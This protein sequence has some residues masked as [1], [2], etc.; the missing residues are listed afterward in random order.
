[1]SS[2]ARQTWLSV[3][4]LL[5]GVST[6]LPSGATAS[7]S[8]AEG[9]LEASGVQGG[10]VVH[11]GCGDGGLTS[12][13]CEDRFLVHGLDGNPDNVK[14]AREALVEAGV[15]DRAWIGHWLGDRLPYAD[16]VVNLL[17]DESVELRVSGEEISRVL[18]PGGVALI[19]TPLD[20]PS[21]T[22][23]ASPSLPG[24]KG[25]TK[26]L[27][28]R[29]DTIDEWTH[30]LHDASCNA[31]SR[32]S[33]VGP[34]TRMQWIE[35]PVWSKHHKTVAN[36][37]AMVSS[38]GRLFYICEESLPSIDPRVMPDKWNLVARDAFN[39]ILLWRIPI[40]DWGW[41]AWS[42]IAMARNNQPTHIGRRLVAVG[43]RV[44]VTLGYNEPVTEL[45]AATGDVMR[46]L[47]GTE[48]TDAILCQ[49]GH[50]I[51][52]INR[53][54]QA[55]TPVAAE[56][57]EPAVRKSVAVVDLATG[58][59]L[60]KKGDYEGLR[61]KTGTMDRINHL[62]M[63]VGE[64]RIYFLANQKELVC[65]DLKTGDQKWSV[66]RPAVE[67]HTMRYFLRVT[68][69]CTLVYHD[70]LVFFA[71]PDP[72]GRYGHKKVRAH[73]YAFAADTGTKKWEKEIAEWGW[74]EPP[75]VFVIKNR[76]W[77]HDLDTFSLLAL[78]PHSGTE[79]QRFP[80]QEALDKGH[81]HRC[82]RN[83]SAEN[84]VMT[85][86]RGLELFDLETG[87]NSLNP[88][89][90]GACQFGY[91]PCNGLV[92]ATP[93]PCDCFINSKLNG[94]LALAPKRAGATGN[95]DGPQAANRF[96]KGPAFGECGSR[97]SEAFGN[98]DV[99]S[100]ADAAS[101]IPHSDFRFP[102]SNDW[103]THRH[104]PARSGSTTTVVPTSLKRMWSV[105]V[106][107][108]PTACVVGEGK[109]LVAS[110]DTHRVHAFD[111]E[112]GESMW[113]A[114]LGGP[115]DSPPTIHDG[116]ALC[117]SLDGW[118]VCLRLSDGELAWR[119]RAAPEPRRIIAYGRLESAWPVHGGILVQHGK[120][121]FTAGRSSC[122]DGGIYAHCVDPG[123][124]ESEQEKCLNATG[125]S[126][127]ACLA[128]VL[129]GTGDA[130]FMRTRMVFGSS[131]RS[132]VHVR[133]D[134]GLLDEQW[135]N[136]APWYLGGMTAQYL[137]HDDN[138][139]Y[140]VVA[141]GTDRDQHIFVPGS[142]GYR[143]YAAEFGSGKKPRELWSVHLP[144]RVVAMVNTPTALFAGGTPDLVKPDDPW[145][146][147]EG[148]LGG[149]LMIISKAD[150]KT[151]S[152]HELA[153]PP[154]TDGVAAADGRLFICLN[155]GELICMGAGD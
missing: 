66:Q 24:L 75:D 124:C 28:P 12:Q 77:V 134:S 88:F 149:R 4:T 57:P 101:N 106:Q 78:D 64:E 50:L 41:K 29:P 93:H 107:G 63:A 53:E 143:L 103:P 127:D 31:V 58:R 129:V 137:V 3:S 126:T 84:Y 23:V 38:S 133:S 153:A 155:N 132:T 89:V 69:R 131:A 46:V 119:F 59:M 60:W 19:R 45:N 111:Q 74:A 96:V 18:V 65:Q 152:E 14:R 5:L 1:M 139:L 21:L 98:V 95:A 22:L 146:A 20:T 2:T 140:G 116:A 13:I 62:T 109:V 47:K 125:E 30:H 100:G 37:D 27:R 115:M 49:D 61:S 56:S 123:T 154:V 90:R 36:V 102:R 104:D 76:L 142:K 110:M 128:D 26:L 81:H 138:T 99:G 16:G 72:S 52:T 73:I 9:I 43:D 79:L 118:V 17:I 67:E 34:P 94:V 92:Y 136:R 33:M 80:T 15:A 32:D 91:V 71:Q 122:L 147:L 135:F 144:A 48:H 117:G 51:L 83:R 70:G 85:S 54:P 7:A 11:V 35:K 114:T 141:C 82:Y 121:Y 108:K 39:G 151:L 87:E 148:R 97:G 44:Y 120:A 105:Q 40:D 150:G 86:H 113:T 42:G 55:P 130:V 68:D 145:A 6:L 112:T 25:W 10:L 8:S